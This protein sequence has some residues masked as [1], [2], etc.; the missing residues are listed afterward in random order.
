M[1]DID[2]LYVIMPRMSLNIIHLR[3]FYAVATEG[4]FSA[5]ARAAHVSQPTLSSQ[6][7]ALEERYGVRLF[8]R[9]GRG[10]TLTDTGARL[11]ELARRLFGLEEQAEEVLA[12]AHGLNSG[13]LRVGADGP[14]HAIPLLARFTRRYP[15]IEVA[16][17]MGSADR[18]LRDLRASRI[19]VALVARTGADPRL[20]SLTY[21]TSP[22]V[23]F[24]PRDHAWARRA[25]ICLAEIRGERLIVR[26][27]ASM[28]RQV[29]EAALAESAIEPAAVMCIE[30]REAVR[31][32]VAAGLGI[33]VVAAAE[34]DPD[35]R[36]KA[37][38]IR[39]AQLSITEHLVCLE[40]RRSLRV[41]AAFLA[42]ARERM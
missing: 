16:L 29:F 12:A 19:D 26:E 39:D 1:F 4:G 37:L 13:R 8:E 2:D 5:A 42:V 17:E 18:M 14:H 34:F 35:R 36:V 27:A 23:I 3:A 22:L 20:H 38:R 21:L 11:L 15:G 25:S 9:A 41:L 33:G 24:V 31:E 7:H 28:T 40:E 30:S 32:A 6:V 10:I